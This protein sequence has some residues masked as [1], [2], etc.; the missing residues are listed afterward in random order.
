MSSVLAIESDFYEKLKQVPVAILSDVMT[1]AGL[2]DR[3]LSCRIRALA[4]HDTFAGPAFC[5][6]ADATASALDLPDRRFEMYRRMPAGAVVVMSTGQYARTAAMGENMVTAMKMRGC[7]GVVTDSGYRDM[8]SIARDG[9]PVRAMFVSPVSSAGQL[10][11]VALDEPVIMPGQTVP[12]VHVTPG[13]VIVS[14]DEGTLVIPA[15]HAHSIYEDAQGV[16]DAEER[17]RALIL[18]GRDVEEAY[19]ANDRFG[20]VRKVA[21]NKY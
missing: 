3:V 9:L 8:A 19:K 6:Q 21:A 1:K 12:F 20:H 17:T 5:V 14:D 7:V 13:D 16:F 18:A 10:R 2:P 4:G 15:Q 11:F